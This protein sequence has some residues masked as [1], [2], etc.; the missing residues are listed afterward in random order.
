M[1]INNQLG[2][3]T[4]PNPVYQKSVD[5]Q[6]GF[7]GS[8]GQGMMFNADGGEYWASKA[9]PNTSDDTL[10]M[11]NEDNY[12]LNAGGGGSGGN[13]IV[14][15]ETRV[16]SSA[17]GQFYDMW[18]TDISAYKITNNEPL[19]RVKGTYVNSVSGK[20]NLYLFLT[21]L[22]FLK[23]G[24]DKGLQ[25]LLDKL[26]NYPVSKVGAQT[27]AGSD[28]NNR[29]SVNQDIWV[30]QSKVDRLAEIIKSVTKQIEDA[31]IK[32]DNDAFA[33]AKSTNT[34]ASYSDYLNRFPEG[35]SVEKARNGIDDLKKAQTLKELEEKK[36]TAT[37]EE[38]KQIDAEIN[39]LLGIVT[40]PLKGM[41][42]K[43]LLYGG[44]GL[45]V[46]FVLYKILGTKKATN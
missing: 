26:L 25:Q 12:F 16:R 20:N 11:L 5:Q 43:I 44:A 32:E 38:K 36:K 45:V 14:D 33:K 15:A 1:N 9:Q 23:S 29:K 30:I 22:N 7:I 10:L 24:Y 34:I 40:T 21:E 35:L 19:A 13:S 37:P 18:N 3:A 41:G 42:G 28:Y 46:I 4:H 8:D 2:L 31:K 6:L 27:R 39:N 17:N